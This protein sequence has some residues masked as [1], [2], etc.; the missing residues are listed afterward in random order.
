MNGVKSSFQQVTI[1]FLAVVFVVAGFSR[2]Q[3]QTA[4][5]EKGIWGKLSSGEEVHRYR[6]SDGSTQAEICDYG[7]QILGWWQEVPGRE[8]WVNVVRG[9]ANFS[10]VEGGPVLGA[11]IG[12]YAN[13]ISGGGFTIDGQRYD[14]ES[15]NQ[16]GIQIHGGKTGF[17]RQ[18]WQEEADPQAV[19]F[20]AAPAASVTLRLRSAD[21]HEGFPGNMTVWVQYRLVADS[22]RYSRLEMEFRA[23]TDKPTHLN[24]T[25][26][27]YF[28]VSGG[29]GL[30]SCFLY[31]SEKWQLLEF[32]KNKI[33][34]GSFLPPDTVGDFVGKYQNLSPQAAGFVPLD[35]CYR[36]VDAVDWEFGMNF[37]GLLYSHST[38]LSLRVQT[39]QPGVQ[40]YTAN[41]FKGQ[42]MPKHGAICFETQHFPDTPNRPEFPSTLLRP[43]EG[44]RQVTVYRLA[45][46][47]LQFR[48]DD[49]D[50]GSTRSLN[51]S[52]VGDF[53]PIDYEHLKYQHIDRYQTPRE[54][55][56]PE[57][58][59]RLPRLPVLKR[60]F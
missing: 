56:M 16:K 57:G 60:G 47:G 27:A 48:V 44:Y 23:E 2:I 53:P 43:G 12:R 10:Q 7:A 36:I 18:L 5:V 14:L 11:V 39:T 50:V 17:Q 21:G 28:D 51:H 26:H 6:L 54:G 40:I 58:G 49:R 34:T 15:V 42:P 20:D 9:P 4:S 37:A 22:D 31:G 45:V 29:E 30:E 33:P 41:H 3:G 35:H 13:R 46:S 59:T 8:H 55:G 32:D 52:P 25:N 19:G 1:F 38:G 24:L